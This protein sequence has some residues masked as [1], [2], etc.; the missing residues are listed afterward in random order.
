M[1]IGR[2]GVVRSVFTST[3]GARET[4]ALGERLRD[5]LARPREVLEGIPE[6]ATPEEVRARSAEASKLIE[7][8]RRI[9]AEGGDKPD[10]ESRVR[11]GDYFRRSNLSR[12]FLKTVIDP[13]M[14]MSSRLERAEETIEHWVA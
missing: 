3:Y 11:A 14:S 12:R 2:G 1:E 9:L 8:G 6:E 10:V 7:R 13:L 4:I 5:G